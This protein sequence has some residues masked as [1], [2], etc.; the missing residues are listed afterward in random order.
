VLALL[1]DQ[2]TSIPRFCVSHGLP[3]IVLQRALNGQRRR[4]TVD[5]ACSVEDATDGHVVC[6]DWRSATLADGRGALPRSEVSPKKGKKQAPARKRSSS[7][8]PQEPASTSLPRAKKAAPAP[9]KVKP[10]RRA[11][12]KAPKPLRR[13]AGKKAA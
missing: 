13:E 6:A 2:G 7:P 1:A 4:F 5:F 11:P 10:T 3:R 12:V 8:L 9:R